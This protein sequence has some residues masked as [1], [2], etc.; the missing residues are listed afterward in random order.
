MDIKTLVL[1]QKQEIIDNL[2]TLV[3]YPSMLNKE[4]APYPF[5]KNNADCLNAAL[6]IC[7]DY[8]F[9]TTNLDNY[10]GYAEIGTGEKLIGVIGHLDVVPVADG[11]NT[12][13]FEATIVNDKIYG[14]GTSDDKGPMVCAMTAV[15]IV[16]ELRPNLNKRIRLIMGSNEETGMACLAHYVKKEGHID[17]GFTPDGGFPCIHGEKG[18][19]KAS[20]ECLSEH[21]H[22]ITAG[23]AGNVVPNK[24]TMD[25]DKDTF[26]T[27]K[28][29]NYFSENNIKYTLTD[30]GDFWHLEVLGVSAHASLPQAGINAVSFAVVGLH[31]A[32][33]A[34]SF[35]EFYVKKIGTNT[36]GKGL[37]VDFKDQ[38]GDLTLNIGVVSQK[39]SVVTGTIDIRFPVTENSKHVID[40]MEA[41][42]E[43]E[44]AKITIGG[45]SEPLYYPTDS[46]LI[47]LLYEAYVEV[48][49]D[50][51]NKP[52]T[53]GGGTYARGINNCVAFGGVFPDAEDCHMHD[54]NEFVV[55][56]ELLKQTE[57]YVLALLKLLDA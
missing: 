3:S 28:L 56:D 40:T 38:Y 2:K 44:T 26:D 42:M 43:N 8:G 41:N 19:V 49:G 9:A 25:I 54:S 52:E 23:I 20:F 46:P 10:C 55:I 11:W 34:D 35:V 22:N 36:D 32:G 5:G 47:S 45:A 37:D 18:M 6:A 29:D 51:V 7:N 53:M 14:R 1:A 33:M 16:K 30:N 4:E 17:M 15:K 31:E 48:T 39:E 12:P 27:K 57:I 13:P 50:T 21:I 24:V